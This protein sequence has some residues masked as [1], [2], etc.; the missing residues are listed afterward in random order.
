MGNVIRSLMVRVGADLTDFDKSLKAMSK[1]LKTAG[2]EITA[3]GKSLTKGLTAPVLGAATALTALAVNA[4]NN[5]GE[6]LTL[7]QKTGITTQ[8]LQELAYA[9]RFVDVEMETMT[10]SMAK[11]IKSQKAAQDGTKLSVDAYKKLGLNLEFADNSVEA[12]IY[13]VWQRLSTGRLKIFRS[14]TNTLAEYR[15]YRRDEKGRI[16]KVND[17]L[18][19]CIRYLCVSGI[20]R[21]ITKPGPPKEQKETY[22]SGRGGGSW[23]G[24]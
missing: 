22:G 17:H 2:K 9:S 6:L 13:E 4:G 23:M 20:K 15:V 12:G 21:A 24:A 19:D 10:G 3:T 16:V 18:M 11:Q 8:R 14:C 1:E 7:S 5:A